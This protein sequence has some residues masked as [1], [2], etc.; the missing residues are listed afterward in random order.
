MNTPKLQ[1]K[2]HLFLEEK[3]RIARQSI[4]CGESLA[5]KDAQAIFAERRQKLKIQ[6]KGIQHDR[7]ASTR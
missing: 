5:H 4:A 6:K 3:V 1:N 2:Y 7:Q